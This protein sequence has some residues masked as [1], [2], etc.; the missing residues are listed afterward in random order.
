MKK[1]RY[2]RIVN[3]SS[4]MGSFSETTDPNSVYSELLSPAYRYFKM[5][6]NAMT[7]LLAKELRDTNILV[8]TT[9]PGWVGTRLG[10]FGPLPETCT[11]LRVYS[12][13]VKDGF[14]ASRH[15]SIP[16]S[17][18][19]GLGRERAPVMPEQAAVT[20]VW[21]ATLPDNGPTGGFSGNGNRFPGNNTPKEAA[22][23][24][25]HPSLGKP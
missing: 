4:L 10:P 18:F 1:N 17:G 2:G 24:P 13:K 14:Y 25:I 19:A 9:C 22:L 7:V 6:L 15:P 21:L 11:L 3:I 8:N 5:L 20:P 23:T 12:P 16:A